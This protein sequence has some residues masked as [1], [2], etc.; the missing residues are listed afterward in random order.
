[1]SAKSKRKII[2]SVPHGFCPSVPP[3]FGS[4]TS[5]LLKKVE[6]SDESECDPISMESILKLNDTD[7]F[8]AILKKRPWILFDQSDHD[9]E[10]SHTQHFPQVC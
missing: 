1:M 10:K 2:P 3:G 5:L 7:A 8:K 9:L 4:L 6:K